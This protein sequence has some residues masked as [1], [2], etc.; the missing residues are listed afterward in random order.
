MN[1]IENE[2][3]PTMTYM[4]YF[5]ALIYYIIVFVCPMLLSKG[6]CKKGLKYE[7]Y[8]IYAGFVAYTIIFELFS[9]CRL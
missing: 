5:N 4:L 1:K 8:Y 9:L 3:M 2:I 7:V 6:S